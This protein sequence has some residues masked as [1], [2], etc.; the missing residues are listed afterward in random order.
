MRIGGAFVAYQ[1]QFY[2]SFFGRWFKVSH[3]GTQIVSFELCN[4]FNVLFRRC[5]VLHISF[6]ISI[7]LGYSSLSCMLILFHL[8]LF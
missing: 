1:L 2:E 4:S 6:T 3:S 8:L 7:T 5:F